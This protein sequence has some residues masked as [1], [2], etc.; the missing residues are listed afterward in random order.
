[1]LCLGQREEARG[2]RWPRID[3]GLRSKG[4]SLALETRRDDSTR[5][6]AGPAVQPQSFAAGRYSV[7]RLIG[8][9]GQKIVYLARDTQL[10]RDV[11][12]AVLKTEGLDETRV[13]RVR[14]EAQAMARLEAHSQI[15]AI[16]DIGEHEGRPYTVC[17]Y[18]PGGD[19]EQALR[20]AGGALPIERALAIARDVCSA[21][22]LTHARTVLHRDIKPSNIWLT[23]DGSAK[24]GD[25]GL[26]VAEGR[27]RLTQEGTVL[28]TAVYMAP[29]QALGGE[30]DARADLY[31]LGCVL[32]ELVTGRP[33]F[34]GDDTIAIVSQHINTAPVAP[35]WHRSESRTHSRCSS[36]SSSRSRHRSGRKTRP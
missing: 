2:S 18:V 10:D 3:G 15:V 5:T 20:K 27:S 29:E 35:S 23:A 28:G 4:A 24:I 12:I 19:L 8:E 7:R 14:R 9:G 11:A 16:Y 25:F 33:P 32:Y 36:C 34:V 17:E 21:L 26:A 13:A 1:L 30:V 31:S 6:V 22:A